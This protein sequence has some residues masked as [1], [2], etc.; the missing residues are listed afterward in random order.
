MK[1]IFE[2][3]ELKN[4]IVDKID[5]DISY[6]FS[7]EQLEGTDI[8]KLDN[9]KIN[10]YINKNLLGDYMLNLNVDGKMILPC[11]LT[12]KDVIYPFSFE[13][14]GEINKIVE[15]IDEFSKNFENSID[16]FPIIW[17]NILMEIPMKVV[18]ED[19]R[20]LKM[21]GNGWKLITEEDDHEEIN[22]E[23]AK[24]KDLF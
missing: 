16:I 4:N 12:L 6:D 5:I 1:M 17:E 9:V 2:L 11:A 15:E 23:L 22:P 14:N 7:K 20:D 24:L 10:G 13:I 21:E 19:A 18:S 8:R 3:L